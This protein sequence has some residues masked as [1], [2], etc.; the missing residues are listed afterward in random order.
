M[1]KH[2]TQIVKS[3]ETLQE[4]IKYTTIDTDEKLIAFRQ[5]LYDRNITT[6]AVDFEA[7]YNLHEYG[8][9]LCLIQVFDGNNYFIIDPFL[10]SKD[11]IIKT[12]EY[13]KIV[14]LFYG[15]ES[16]KSLVFKQY[17]IKIKSVYDQKVLVDVLGLEEKS[18]DKIILRTLGININTKRNYQLYNWTKRPL[19]EKAIQYALTDV[20]YLFRINTELVKLI[21]FE[22]KINDL[23][24]RLIRLNDKDDKVPTPRIYRS[25][26]YRVLSD[27]EKNR[28]KIIMNIREDI[29]YEYNIPPTLLLDK[30]H[31][32]S[33][34]KDLSVTSTLKSNKKVSNEMLTK[35]ITRINSEC[36]NNQD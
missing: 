20:Q 2:K 23:A 18:L 35:M 3:S 19:D 22:N 11:E 32:V 27:K 31:M 28:F 12:L 5:D 17:G 26:E 29:A 9:K 34:S 33:I 15:S 4:T 13:H 14:K 6:I 10:I 8:E 24:I 16:D 30:E 21:S 25:H 1:K 7:E 36:E